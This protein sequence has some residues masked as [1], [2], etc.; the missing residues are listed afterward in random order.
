M[1]PAG[2][3]L[4][5]FA[6]RRVDLAPEG[7]EIAPPP[8]Q[9]GSGAVRRRSRRRR[10]CSGT[11]RRARDRAECR[12]AWPPARKT[13]I[14]DLR[15]RSM[16][17]EFR[18]RAQH[19]GFARGALQPEHQTSGCWPACQSATPGRVA[20]MAPMMA[21]PPRARAAW[22]RLRPSLPASRVSQRGRLLIAGRFAKRAHQRDSPHMRVCC[23]T[24]LRRVI[25]VSRLQCQEAELYTGHGRRS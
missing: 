23:H 25:N 13:L 20:S 18:A 17:T 16:S 1:G 22:R 11:G 2:A 19:D 9:Q 21:S 15:P 12:V 4:G 3:T 24:L 10:G 14:S 5:G 7:G 8:S 6:G